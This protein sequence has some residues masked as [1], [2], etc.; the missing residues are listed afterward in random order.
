MHQHTLCAGGNKYNCKFID[1]CQFITYPE[2]DDGNLTLRA[3]C[4]PLNSNWYY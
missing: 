1:S 3:H 2:I 4:E